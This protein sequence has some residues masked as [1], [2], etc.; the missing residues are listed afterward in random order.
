MEQHASLYVKQNLFPQ[1]INI[2]IMR[3]LKQINFLQDSQGIEADDTDMQSN[4]RFHLTFP[5]VNEK[6]RFFSAT[7]VE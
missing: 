3:H 2:D 4:T 5:N 1:V 6:Q 7:S